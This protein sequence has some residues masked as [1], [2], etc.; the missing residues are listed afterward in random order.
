MVTFILFTAKAFVL[1]VAIALSWSSVAKLI[2]DA[3]KVYKDEFK[4]SHVKLEIWEPAF[5]WGI[6]YLIS[7]YV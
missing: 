6:F 4:K 3:I 5:A 1:A 2:L 7:H